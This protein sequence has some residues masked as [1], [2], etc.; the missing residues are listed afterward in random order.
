MVIRNVMEE[1]AARGH[2]VCNN[3]NSNCKIN[4]THSEVRRSSKTG[5]RY[6]FSKHIAI[7]KR[8]VR[9]ALSSVAR[10]LAIFRGLARF[11]PNHTQGDF[12]HY[13]HCLFKGNL[14]ETDDKTLTRKQMRASH[15]NM[16]GI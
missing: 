10:A 5:F 4:V 12:M 3:F 15:K 9:L 6:V 7:I 11:F 13:C 8:Y 2:E 1:L 14:R 16:R